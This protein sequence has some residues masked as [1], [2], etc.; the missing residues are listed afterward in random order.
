MPDIDNIPRALVPAAFITGLTSG[1]AL[2]GST[3][4][5]VGQDSAFQWDNTN[6]RLGIGV[7]PS[8]VVDVQLPAAAAGSW[9]TVRSVTHGTGRLRFGSVAASQFNQTVNLS[10]DG[11]AYSQDDAA[12]TSLM[13]QQITAAALVDSAFQFARTAAGSTSV[14]NLMRIQADGNVLI[15]STTNGSGRLQVTLSGTPATVSAG[16]PVIV[17][18][19]S[20]QGLN[21][22]RDVTNSIEMVWGSI[23]SP[24]SSGL[25]GTITAHEL[26]FRTNNV[27]RISVNTS[28]GTNFLANVAG[29]PSIQGWNTANGTAD[30]LLKVYGL[31]NAGAIRG[32]MEVQLSGSQTDTH[33]RMYASDATNGLQEY[34]RLADSTTNNDTMLL[35][36]RRGNTGTYSLERVTLGAADSGGA[37]FRVMRVPN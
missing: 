17:S 35:V 9:V 26:V 10:W 11:A 34:A 20:G 6:K 24:S 23:T 13:F 29:G 33:L 3:S 4:G 27:S 25:I 31:N 15:G 12:R 1:Q 32:G 8:T 19:S 36:R 14:T 2:F 37:G 7:A 21:V 30:Y 16:S 28:F 5:G 18:Y 22:H